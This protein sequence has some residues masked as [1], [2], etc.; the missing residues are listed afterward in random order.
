MTTGDYL[1]IAGL[2]AAFVGTPVAV[3][4]FSVRALRSDTAIFRASVAEDVGGLESRMRSVELEKVN[5]TDWIRE[6][7]S[8]RAKIDVI[9][10]DIAAL[11]AKYDAS[12]GIGASIQR[13]AKAIE[14]LAE[15]RMGGK[16]ER[17]G[18]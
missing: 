15:S 5:R 1:A 18:R 14:Q 17:D 4:T 12:L 8:V 3:L 16:G 9:G 13:T 7:V 11:S 10:R 2:L 6:Q